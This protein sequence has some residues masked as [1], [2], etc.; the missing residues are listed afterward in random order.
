MTKHLNV[1]AL[2]GSLFLA[3]ILGFVAG[4]IRSFQMHAVNSL[5]LQRDERLSIPVITI[6]A[7]HD[8]VIEGSAKGQVRLIG[9]GKSV[10]PDNDGNF[11]I[12]LSILRRTVEVRVPPN[13]QFVASKKG[14]KYYKVD[15]PS[16]QRLKPE[17]RVYFASEK[18][19]EDAGFIR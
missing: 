15:S 2:I 17:T 6:D 11:Q 12:P 18:E 9:E 1:L 16:G 3:V 14:K 19:A 7:I 13:A 4:R 8:G 5:S 10:T